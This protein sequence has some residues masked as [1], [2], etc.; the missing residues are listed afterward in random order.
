MFEVGTKAKILRGSS[1]DYGRIGE[2]IRVE[3]VVVLVDGLERRYCLS[4]LEPVEN[5]PKYKVGSKIRVL[6]TSMITSDAHGKEGIIKE[7]VPPVEPQYSAAIYVNIEGRVF[8]LIE[9]EFEVVE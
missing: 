1:L 4:E 9:G 6:P 2:I 8:Y 3:E 7:I 5:E